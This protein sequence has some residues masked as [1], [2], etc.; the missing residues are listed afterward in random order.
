MSNQLTLDTFK[1]VLPKQ[2]KERVSQELVDS[3]NLIFDDPYEREVYRDNLL[4]FSS[5]LQ[6]GKFKLES[7]ID[8]VRYMGFKMR[9]D[10]NKT[11][12]I[13]TFPDRYQAH[14][15]KGTSDKDISSYV[16]AYNKSILVNKVREQT[17]I[18]SYILNAD[19]FQGALN[20]QYQIMNNDDASFKVQSDAANSIMTHLKVPEA[21][22]M[23]LEVTQKEDKAIDQLRAAIQE[24]TERQLS[25][26]RE[27]NSSALSVAHGSLFNN[28]GKVIE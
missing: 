23:E 2:F 11:A 4:S 15:D 24:F 28:A 16:S 8:A 21:V 5:V 10:L 25:S 22:K 18:P 1:A 9:G 26:I 6:E 3:V 17:L 12:F 27:G 20:K 14:L 19:M 7:Y 13:K